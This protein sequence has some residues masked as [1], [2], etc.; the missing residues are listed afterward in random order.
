M[1]PR[2]R[3]SVVVPTYNR[4]DRLP[5]VL[6]ALDRQTHPVDDLEVVVVSDGST[7]GTD[8]YLAA[9][10]HPRLRFVTQANQGPGAA[11]N[12]GVARAEGSLVLFIDDDV[13]ATPQLVERHVAA[14][15]VHGPGSVVIGP[16]LSPPDFA[17][18]PWVRWEQQMLVRQYE[19]MERG[20]YGATARQFYTGNASVR[21]AELIELGG[22]DVRF[23]RAE[24]VELAYRMDAAGMH[25]HFDSAAVGYHYAQRSFEAWL[26]IASDYG[27]NDVVFAREG[28]KWML[29]RLVAEY[30]SRHRLVRAM[31]AACLDRTAME[32]AL[33]RLLQRAVAIGERLRSERMTS[34][35]LSGLYQLA[36]YRGVAD[37]LG[38]AGA[39]DALLARQS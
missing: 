32:A 27:A 3:V 11:R 20:D 9:L 36:F 37:E 19:A 4:L 24:D 34:A 22:F 30:R 16:M 14:H 33:R 17:M 7:D 21:R 1:T 10:H 15:T 18:T 31:T 25:F 5:R 6:G 29:D 35:A 26:R 39:F 8:D 12:A 2:P 13:V 23:R 28:R 38:G